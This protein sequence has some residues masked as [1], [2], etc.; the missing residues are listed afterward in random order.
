MILKHNSIF[1]LESLWRILLVYSE[2]WISHL[3]IHGTLHWT[4]PI[5]FYLH[6]YV[7]SDPTFSPSSNIISRKLEIATF[8]FVFVIES[9]VI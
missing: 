5:L 6:D 7:C 2:V 1:E 3:S 9:I 8:K 4:K